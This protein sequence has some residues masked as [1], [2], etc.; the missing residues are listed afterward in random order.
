[1]QSSHRTTKV[2][3]R[4]AAWLCCPLFALGSPPGSAQGQGGAANHAPLSIAIFVSS[5]PDSCFDPGDVAAIKRLALA[6]QDRINASGGA[7]RRPLTLRILDDMRIAQR[8][9]VNV[10]DALADPHTVAMIGLSNSTLAKETFD[11]I[12]ASIGT[13]GVP[14]LSDIAVN[15]VYEPHANVF[16]MRPSQDDERVPVLEQFSKARN[17]QR[18]AFVG[19][20]DTLFSSSLG[21]G[22]K[23]SGTGASLVADH[24]LGLNNNKLDPA[25]VTAMI[26]DLRERD[27]DMVFLAIGAN[28][29]AP[30]LAAF[31]AAGMTP[32]VFVTGRID[33]IVQS[34]AAEYPGDIY[35][36]AWDNLPDVFS[37]RLRDR[38]VRNGIERWIFEGRKN[39]QAP[40]WASGE[41]KARAGSESNVFDSR[42]MLAIGRGTQYA[43]MV[44]L[45]ADALKNADP[46]ADVTQL[47]AHLLTQLKTTYAA[48]RGAFRGSFDNWSFRPDSRA[49]D[50][51]PFVVM[52]PNGLGATQ[53]APVQFVRL[54]TDRLRAI[55]TLYL[56]IDLIRIFR[57]DD[58]DKS[59][60]AEFYLSMRGEKASID[61]V[62]F[63]NAF[64]DPKTNG[65]QITVRTLHA[66]GPSET[67]P[68]EMQ[69]YLVSGKFMFEPRFASYPFDSQRFAVDI[70]PK[71][72]EAPF[73]VQP[74]PHS[75]RDK[76][77]ITDGWDPQEHYV[78]Y[79]EDFVPTVDAWTHRQSIVP[80]YKASFVWLMQRQTIDYFL[81]VVVPLAFILVV[82]Y[83]SIFIPQTHFEAIVTI[84]VTALLSS[85]ALY[86]ALPKID[87]DST[88]LSDRIF[89]F[90]YM[91]VSL[92]I[93]LSILRV[94]HSVSN[95][96][97]LKR[98]LGLVHIAA[99]PLLVG[100]MAFYLHR[101]SRG[102]V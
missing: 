2:Y 29:T 48:G 84:Q 7:L 18:P 16:T 11:A 31:A 21:D 22:L 43:D 12:G 66:G 101:V 38:V 102:G 81:R 61:K 52:R 99:I 10:K 32:P 75:V 57:V 27:T 80:F 54:R 60:F 59:F 82:A 14:F 34:G 35:Q 77:V 53:L 74:P 28:R 3:R 39:A 56:D 44:A 45:V 51:T 96:R 79:D 69:V 24:R 23:R 73:I 83:M 47:R 91:A 30:V 78:G 92:M 17:V 64:L 68:A 41:C 76:A 85:V 88:T 87:A 58:N 70:Q 93:G 62:E 19:L 86:L 65:R 4:L 98:A 63:A 9:I 90:C 1:V 15:S 13:S 20:K 100:A 50:R 67:Y 94:N 26:A 25:E 55:D 72:G 71:S 95:T 46:K 6:E 33:T 8:T 42:N 49:A 36:L 40:G 97:W 5:R 37:D 89:L